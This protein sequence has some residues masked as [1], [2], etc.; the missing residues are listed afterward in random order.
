MSAQD[1]YSIIYR[2]DVATA[3][4]NL[5]KYIQTA[6]TAF[7]A[8]EDLEA[9]MKRLGRD[10]SLLGG[11]R[12]AM[13]D[14]AKAVSDAGNRATKTHAETGKIGADRANVEALL[15]Q[16]EALNAALAQTTANANQAGG[17]AAGV[18]PGAGGEGG[19]GGIGGAG[20]GK[21]AGRAIAV[22]AARELLASSRESFGKAEQA[23]LGS[24]AKAEEMRAAVQPLVPLTGRTT[25]DDSL[26]AEQLKLA[27]ATGLSPT[28]AAKFSEVFL[29][30]TG[31]G[32]ARF[33]ATGGKQGISEE[34]AAKLLP[35]AAAF[36]QR[37]GI[38]PEV[39]GKMIGS[40]GEFVP[41]ASPEQAMG[42]FGQIEGHL[43]LGGLGTIRELS[44]PFQGLMGEF[45]GEGGRI[46]DPVRL[47]A[48]FAAE[49]NRAKSAAVA[50]TELK[51][52]NRGLRK[53]TEAG[54]FGLTKDMDYT[55]GIAQL[56]DALAGMDDTTAT[57]A[58]YD[59]GVHESTEV[60]SMIKQAKLVGTVDEA[61][62]NEKIKAM[63]ANALGMNKTYL[64]SRPGRTAVGQARVE[65]AEIRRGMPGEAYAAAMNQARARLIDRGE[66]DTPATNFGDWSMG[67]VNPSD[68]VTGRKNYERRIYNEAVGELRKK[69]YTTP[70]IYSDDPQTRIRAFGEMQQRADAFDASQA[71]RDIREAAANLNAA[72]QHAKAA[73]KDAVVPMRP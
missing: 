45:A 22:S 56:R 34:T 13:A 69:T 9:L 65:A 8:T 25:A 62:K 26:M 46:S 42:I 58:L 14:L 12:N 18:G 53:L 21:W 35:H 2:N 31:S 48:T 49:T 73:G 4:A 55:Q 54:K 15:K 64:E 50:A 43:N 11:Y 57:R 23:Q 27:E 70:E 66:I 39:A 47:A 16:V 36:S 52:S 30:A 51:Q 7:K 41:I 67:M 61:M 10:T 72:A 68:W 32:T 24:I 71:G 44:R 28:D 59:A 38:Q 5:E 17:A 40:I 6:R 1:T 63:G 20:L 19:G 29:G 37:T 3:I 33:K 60:A